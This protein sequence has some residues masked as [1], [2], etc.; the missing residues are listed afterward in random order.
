[1][2]FQLRLGQGNGAKLQWKRSGQNPGSIAPHLLWAVGVA[3]NSLKNAS[4]SETG[5]EPMKAC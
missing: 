1:M 2:P 3:A 5:D 4:A